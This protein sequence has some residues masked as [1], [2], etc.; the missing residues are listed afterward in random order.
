MLGY[1]TRVP[2]DN[3][4]LFDRFLVIETLTE[5]KYLQKYI[6][7]HLEHNIALMSIMMIFQSY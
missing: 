2:N 5:E 7:H 1:L 6:T 4:R 3:E